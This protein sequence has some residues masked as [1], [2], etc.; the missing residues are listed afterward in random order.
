MA[1][2]TIVP[3]SE[4]LLRSINNLVKIG[5]VVLAFG[6]VGVALVMVAN[7]TTGDSKSMAFIAGCI[8]IFSCLAFFLLSSF[9]ILQLTQQIREKLP[10]LDILQRVA[11]QIVDLASLMQSFTSKYLI[12][13]HN[14]VDTVTPMIESLPVIGAAAKLTGLTDAAKIS[15]AIVSATEST[16]EIV[17]NLQQAIRSG[18]L[19]TI[20]KYASQLEISMKTLKG[21]LR[22]DA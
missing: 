12:T 19:E 4:A 20:N 16:Q 8:L 10:L 2:E 11:L 17:I 1:N 3:V 21:A 6:F 14:A 22:T 9:R 13:V 18:D 7:F 5:G 15:G